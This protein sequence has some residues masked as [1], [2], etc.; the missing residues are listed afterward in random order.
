MFFDWKIHIEKVQ[1]T[2]DFKDDTIIYQ[3]IGFLLKMTK[4]TA[5]PLHE[6]NQHLSGFPKTLVPHFK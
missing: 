1:V 3:G 5:M 2:R 6:H 4:D